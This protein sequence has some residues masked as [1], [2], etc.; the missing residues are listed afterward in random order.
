MCLCVCVC[1][2]E[3]AREKE[4]C[5]TEIC[6]LGAFT[7]LQKATISLFMSVRPSVCRHG[8]R[9]SIWKDFH[10]ISNVCIILKSVERIQDSLKSDKNS[11][12]FT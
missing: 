5:R 3:G 1:V 2:C 10:E 12:Q 9:G 4:D 6:F 11:G 8:Q 7:K